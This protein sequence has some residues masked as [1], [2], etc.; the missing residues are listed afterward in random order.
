MAMGDTEGD[1]ILLALEGNDFAKLRHHERRGVR[2]L[3]M[4]KLMVLHLAEYKRLLHAEAGRVLTARANR[5][6]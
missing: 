2:E 3:A 6:W 5:L 4:A 1:R